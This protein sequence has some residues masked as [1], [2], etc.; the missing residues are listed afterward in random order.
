MLCPF[1]PPFF[2]SFMILFSTVYSWSPQ[3]NPFICKILTLFLS[4]PCLLQSYH[5]I[6]GYSALSSHILRKKKLPVTTVQIWDANLTPVSVVKPAYFLFQTFS[7]Q[8]S[9]H[10]SHPPTSEYPLS[11]WSPGDQLHQKVTA[12]FMQP[13][14]QHRKQFG[15]K[16]KDNIWSDPRQLFKSTTRKF[17]Y[18]YNKSA[19]ASET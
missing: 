11:R 3:H 14:S 1:F 9:F 8:Y 4:L 6:H 19:N 10:I 15:H 7:Y 5:T 12:L 16:G 13:N 18:F 17:L 2:S